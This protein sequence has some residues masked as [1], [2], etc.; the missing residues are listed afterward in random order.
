[1]DENFAYWSASSLRAGKLF[2]SSLSLGTDVVAAIANKMF[3]DLPCNLIALFV[4]TLLIQCGP[5][6][7][8]SQ[9]RNL[10]LLC[11]SVLEVIPLAIPRML[12]TSPLPCDIQFDI[13]LSAY[14]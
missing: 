3:S 6:T 4:T 14:A 1:M 7:H 9:D 2:S 5:I 10:T 11:L 12:L 13:R 8:R